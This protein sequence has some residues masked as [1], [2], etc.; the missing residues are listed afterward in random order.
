MSSGAP[1]RP[2]VQG[3]PVKRSDP[4][5][6]A[7]ATKS[8]RSWPSTL[9]AKWPARRIRGH[10]IELRAGQNEISGGLSETDMSESTISGAVGVHRG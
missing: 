3:T 7:R 8:P 6:V 10:V 1:P 4:G 9:T 2:G 5:G